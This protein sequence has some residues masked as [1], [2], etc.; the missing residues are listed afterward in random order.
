MRDE[1]EVIYHSGIMFA[2]GLLRSLHALAFRLFRGATDGQDFVVILL[3]I[4]CFLHAPGHM[5][6]AIGPVR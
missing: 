1:S 5:P 3:V 4:A 6:D 2:P